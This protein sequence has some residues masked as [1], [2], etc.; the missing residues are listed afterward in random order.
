MIRAGA[1]ELS[2]PELAVFGARG[3]VLTLPGGLCCCF[4]D[5]SSEEV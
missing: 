5:H 3:L 1:R 4:L 2:L